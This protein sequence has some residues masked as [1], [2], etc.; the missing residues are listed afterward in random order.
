MESFHLWDASEILEVL[1]EW[2]NKYPNLIKTTTSQ[3]AYGLPH[4]GSIEDCPDDGN[5]VGCS[6]H[7]FTIQD[8]VAHPE[9]SESS[10]RMPEVLWTGSLHGHDLLGPT[11]IMESAALLLEAADC[12]ARPNLHAEAWE[13]EVA[14]AL[15]CRSNLRSRGI[16]DT[17]RQWLARLVTTRRIVVVPNANAVGHFRGEELEDNVNPAEDFPYNNNSTAS[18]MRTVAARTLNEIFLHHMFQVV[19]SFKKGEDAINYSWGSQFY[20]SPDYVCFNEVAGSLSTVVGG[21]TLYPFGPTNLVSVDPTARFQ[22]WAYA[23]SWEHP[24]TIHCLPDTFGGYEAGKTSYP[25]GSNRAAAFTV[26]SNSDEN[27]TGTNLGNVVD[28]FHAA[29]DSDGLAISRSMRLALVSADLVEPYVSIFGI[30]SLA[31]SDDVAPS[32]PR[33]ASLCDTSRIVAVPASLKTVIVEWTV[34]GALS[35]AETDLWVARLEDM[36][37]RAVCSLALDKGFDVSSTAFKKIPTR[38]NSGFGF[39]SPSGPDP[40]PRE[41]VSKP[42]SLLAGH[43]FNTGKAS[44][45]MGGMTIDNGNENDTTSSINLLGPVFRTEIVLDDYEVGDRLI[46][47]ARATVDQA[48]LESPNGYHQV[49]RPSRHAG[50]SAER[51]VVFLHP[52]ACLP[53]NLSASIPFLSHSRLRI[54]KV[55]LPIR[56]PDQTTSMISPERR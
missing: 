52:A 35:I 32:T 4:S 13:E 55:T 40:P 44:N 26:S 34:G 12:E 41:S 56:G 37:D 27:V 16:D 31:I 29:D 42:F 53:C 22:D 7:F 36:P 33:N 18:C 47:I 48:W 10:S 21:R 20:L 1:A 9:G 2:D 23:A 28:V 25:V 11:V 38:L 51:V 24:R 14:K 3:E 45:A 50:A 54:R 30:N 19:L 39:F 8:F 6:N 46:L 49:R 5:R 17:H 43:K 15:S